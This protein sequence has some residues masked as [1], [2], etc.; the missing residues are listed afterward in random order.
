MATVEA[1]NQTDTISVDPILIK[2][3]VDSVNNALEMC[4]LS[5]GCVG[6]SAVP[7]STS[8]I[9]TGIIG[10][11]GK[12]S[13]FITVNLSE[14]FAIKAVEGLL[15]EKHGK[16]NSQIIDGVGELTNIIVGGVKAAIAGTPWQLSHMTVPSVI[17][18]TGYQMAYASGMNFLNVSFEH[19]DAEAIYLADR[20]MQVS[21]SLLPV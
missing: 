6:L 8:G 21:I 12:G 11:H 20:I 15:D 19:K 2:A 9:V 18:G 14:R 5:V 7:P 4:N 16:L 10:V 17:V 13:G 1:P 3:A